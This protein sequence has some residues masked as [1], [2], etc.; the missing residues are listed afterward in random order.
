MFATTSWSPEDVQSLEPDWDLERCTQ[1]LVDNE[2]A[3]RDRLTELGW[4]V[5]E[6]LIV[7]E[8]EWGGR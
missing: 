8:T 3:L 6:D 1:F 5:L 4:T 2:R 7:Y